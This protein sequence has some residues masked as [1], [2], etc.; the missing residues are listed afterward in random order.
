M[1]VPLLN[2]RQ[3]FEEIQ[4]EVLRGWADVLR[5]MKLL[6]GK[7]L[8][9]F[10]REIADY[11]GV[12]HAIGVACGTDALMIGLLA[13]H[14]VPGDEVILQANAFA[15]DIEAI[16]HVGAT[17]VL[18]DIDDNYGP[19]TSAVAA[20]ITNKTKAILIVHMYGMPV[21]VPPLLKISRIHGI[22]LIEDG[23]HA[24]GA[25]YE[26]ALSLRDGLEVGSFG[27]V[28]CF[29]CG[30]VKNLGCYGDGGFITTKDDT[31]KDYIKAIQAH[32]QIVKNEHS[33]IG[34]NSRLDELQAVVLRAKLL[35]LEERNERRRAIAS[36][37]YDGFI[38]LPIK[39]MPLDLDDRICVYH[40]YV[41]RIEKRDEL[42]AYLKS[43]G[44]STGIHY[45]VPLHKQDSWI[46]DE[47]SMPKAEKAAKEIL[48]LPVHPDL[49][50]AEVDYVIQHVTKF[51]EGN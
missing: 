2:L 12:K 47:V 3:E 35:H 41:I 51:F 23:S 30:P 46:Y 29:S 5:S 43:K 15:A 48:S 40:Q 10:E 33:F 9:A 37:Y 31:I 1:K 20:A 22:P 21:F 42:A 34:Y 45:P 16:Y 32:G 24:H 18:V 39:L 25:S 26:V 28:G 49:L 6:K 14:V 36:C 19:D 4:G 7:N 17:P 13:C 11:I 44:I 50:F 38:S 8:Q 27:K